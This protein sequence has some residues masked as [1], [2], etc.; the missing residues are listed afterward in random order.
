MGKM[1]FAISLLA[2]TVGQVFSAPNDSNWVQLLR[3]GDTSLSDWIV[4]IQ[5]QTLGANPYRTFSYAQAND[6]SPRLIVT[7]TVNYANNYGF[8]HLFY[9]TPFSD[10]LLRAQFHFPS[11]ASYA[12]TQG[13]ATGKTWTIQNNGLMLHC[14]SPSSMSV[15]QAYPNSFENQLLGYWNGGAT[16]GFNPPDVRSSNLCLP[17]STVYYNNGSP[18]VSGTG[19]FSDGSGHHCTAAKPHSLAYD[20][21]T[22]ATNGA[23]STNANWLGK[24]IWQYAMARVLDSTS[25]TFFVRNRPDTAWD[26]VMSFSRPHYGNASSLTN[27]NGATVVTSGYISIQM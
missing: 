22:I 4:K 8:G 20:T 16:G 7:D 21:A 17:Q 1:I 6:G 19:W 12:L 9:K 25:M 11:K 2:L 5:G 24:D 13:T 3:Q 15:S 26:S 27:L 14:Q 10:Y 23:N 18:A